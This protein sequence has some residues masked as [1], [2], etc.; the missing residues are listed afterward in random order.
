MRLSGSILTIG[1]VLIG[2]L[3]LA[4]GIRSTWSSFG[5]I[6]IVLIVAILGRTI[7]FGL[8]PLR[9]QG[10][11]SSLRSLAAAPPLGVESD[12]GLLVERSGYRQ[13]VQVLEFTNG[14]LRLSAHHSVDLAGVVLEISQLLLNLL[15][16]FDVRYRRLRIRSRRFAR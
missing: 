6:L 2:C 12:F 3:I 7:R 4:V 9:A 16:V 1:I 15:H 11:L 10:R 5:A 13:V 14:L 8:L